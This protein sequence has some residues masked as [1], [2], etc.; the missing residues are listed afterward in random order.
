[1][2]TQNAKSIFAANQLAEAMRAQGKK[3]VKRLGGLAMA[4]SL[5]GSQASD[6]ELFRQGIEKI[7][8]DDLE[9][10]RQLI[11]PEVNKAGVPQSDSIA[12]QI[13]MVLVGTLQMEARKDASVSWPIAVSAIE[14]LL[15]NSK[16]SLV[17]RY[18]APIV[19]ALF[20]ATTGLI[21][22]QFFF[23]PKVTSKPIPVELL[24]IVPED[25]K[26]PNP[27]VPSHFYTMRQ[28][29]EKM[30]C[31]F[32]QAAMLPEEQRSAFLN[33]INTGEIALTEL[34]SLQL[35]LSKVHCTYPSLTGRQEHL[36]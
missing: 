14:A 36:R 26:V 21:S 31:Q 8:T 23:L 34:T 27:Y 17:L 11:T 5:L 35:A 22:Y 4:L 32:P 7:Q 30:K 28:N 29:M 6:K 19:G 1:M 10:L 2:I 3:P 24:A 18:A 33:F 25:P 12:E 13:L 9:L 15:Q 20:F 16:R